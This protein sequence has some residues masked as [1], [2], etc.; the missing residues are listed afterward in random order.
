MKKTCIKCNQEKEEDQF[1]KGLNCCKICRN[2]YLKEYRDKPE[3]KIK[4]KEYNKINKEHI[5]Q[6]H[7]KYVES[8]KERLELIYKEY[9]EAHKEEKAVYNRQ[10]FIKNKDAL[11]VKR[12]IDK[13][14][15]YKEEPV[16]RLRH[17]VSSSIRKYLKINNSSKNNL[18]CLKYLG[19][20]IDEL[21]KHLESQFEDWMSWENQGMYNKK[22]WDENDPSTWKWQIDHIT[23]QSSLP[24]TSMEDENFK[25][26]WALDNLRPISALENLKKRNL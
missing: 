14:K 17:A 16:F 18:S 2:K 13:K 26:C 25:K 19:Y 3:N 11:N 22:D 15:R 24:Y 6:K 4:R 8:H 9:D 20:T 21:K 10:Y 23:P 1:G 5:K 7:K 12:R